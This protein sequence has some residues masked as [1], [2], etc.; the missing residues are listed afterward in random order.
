MINILKDGT[1]FGEVALL[2]KLKRT[3]T[4]VSDDYSNC[5]YLNKQDVH[6]IEEHFPHIV[7][8]FTSKISEYK[9]EKMSFRRLMIRNIHYLRDLN[10]TIIDEIICHL[11]VK[12]YAKGSTILKNGDVSSKLMFLR[13]GEIDV[14]VSNQISLDEKV[15]DETEL[16]FDKLNTVSFL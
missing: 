12:R 8:H 5:A 11:E 15:T 10:D 14:K 7:R 4:I 6:E 9:D 3:A 16:F 1:L 13:Y 2:T